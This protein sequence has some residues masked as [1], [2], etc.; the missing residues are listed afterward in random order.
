MGRAAFGMCLSTGPNRVGWANSALLAP[1][2]VRIGSTWVERPRQGSGC[3]SAVSPEEPRCKDVTLLGGLQ[4]PRRASHEGHADK[5]YHHRKTG[6]IPCYK[7]N[8]PPLIL[9]NSQEGIKHAIRLSQTKCNMG[10]FRIMR[11]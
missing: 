5:Q 4:T 3:D 7:L 11:S 6:G 1:S 9:L 2:S 10:L 8:M